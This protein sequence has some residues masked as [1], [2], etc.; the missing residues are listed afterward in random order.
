MPK[1]RPPEAAGGAGSPSSS[2]RSR[3]LSSCTRE[4]GVGSLTTAYTVEKPSSAPTPK[5]TTPPMRRYVGVPV[6][7]VMPGTEGG[8]GCP[9]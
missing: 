9:A 4:G 1:M 2:A 7:D 5:E 3:G 8:G 6:V